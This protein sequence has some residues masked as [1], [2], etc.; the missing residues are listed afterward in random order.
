M[1]PTILRSPPSVSDYVSLSEW[2]SQTPETF[3]GG[4]PVL[5]YHATGVLA[6]VYRSQCDSLAFFS[7]PSPL[8]FPEP[9]IDNPDE[10]CEQLVDLFINS[11][12]FTIYSPKAEC[13][14]SLPYPT[15][16]LHAIKKVQ[17]TAVEGEEFPSVYLQLELSDGGEDDESYDTVE[18]TLIP[19]PT[20]GTDKNEPQ[21]EETKKMFEAISEC[22]NL[23]PDPAEDEDEDE[24]E[25]DKIVFEGDIEGRD[26]IPGLPGVYASATDLPPPMPG[27]SGW[28]T[29]ENVHEYFDAEGN[30]IGGEEEGASGELGE[31]AGRVRGREEVEGEGGVNGHGAEGEDGETKRVRTE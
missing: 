19:G 2:Q 14:L 4:K 27:S 6:R 16:T 23:N 12:N 21:P 5:H 18:L 24:D 11:E 1:P 17:N 29:A 22:S 28:I 8:S 10:K 20:P 31:G 25:Y 30:W 26:E 7:N 9:S 15:I 13:G 3:H